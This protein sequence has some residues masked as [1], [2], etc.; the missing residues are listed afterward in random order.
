VEV[1]RK[2]FKGK[3]MA[4]GQIERFVTNGYQMVGILENLFQKTGGLP[5]L[6]GCPES[7]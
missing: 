6:G 1:S 3:D 2:K 5:V 4:A 7:R